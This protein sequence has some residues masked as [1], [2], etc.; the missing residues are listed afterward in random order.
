[1]CRMSRPVHL[2]DPGVRSEPGPAAGCDVCGALA[3]QRE[4]ARSVGDLSKV[5]DC[6]VEMRRHPHALK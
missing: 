3:A 4:R 5:I 6:N 2:P 1:M